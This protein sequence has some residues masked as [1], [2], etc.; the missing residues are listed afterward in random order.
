MGSPDGVGIGQ[1]LR[2]RG[3]PSAGTHGDLLSAEPA[4]G[5]GSGEGEGSLAHPCFLQEGSV[6]RCRTDCLALHCLCKAPASSWSVWKS[7][8]Y[9]GFTF[10][11]EMNCIWEEGSSPAPILAPLGQTFGSWL[12]PSPGLGLGA[13]WDFPDS[14]LASGPVPYDTPNQRH[15]LHQHPNWRP[16]GLCDLPDIYLSVHLINHRVPLVLPH[17]RLSLLLSSVPEERTFA[18]LFPSPNHCSGTP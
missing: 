6:Q 15:R 2:E 7:R 17:K 5:S 14:S 1:G 11:T 4:L 10:A 9:P 16:P 3:V 18:P 8:R 13:F 12:L